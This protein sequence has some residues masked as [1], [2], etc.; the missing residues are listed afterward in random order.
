MKTVCLRASIRHQ[1]TPVV[2]RDVMKVIHARLMKHAIDCPC[3]GIDATETGMRT[4]EQVRLTRDA[5]PSQPQKALAGSP[6]AGRW[7]PFQNDLGGLAL[8]I[9]VTIVPWTA[10]GAQI[11]TQSPFVRVFADSGVRH[12]AGIMNFVVLTAALSSMNTNVYL[13]SRMMFSLAR[14]DYA[15]AIL[16]W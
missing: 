10:T 8:G 1:Q 7:H 12:A 3:R 14:G 2:D 9:V 11:V 6:E 5:S 16:P 15:P 4:R 13:C